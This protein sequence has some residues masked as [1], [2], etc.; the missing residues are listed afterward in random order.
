MKF[1]TTARP[2][3][4]ARTITDPP[5]LELAADRLRNGS[6]CRTAASI[7]LGKSKPGTVRSQKDAIRPKRHAEA[8]WFAK[9]APGLHR[10]TAV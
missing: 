2:T 10:E 5:R 6:A 8:T 9:A 1:H 3:C 7:S 4:R